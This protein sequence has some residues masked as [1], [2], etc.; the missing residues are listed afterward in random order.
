MRHLLVILSSLTGIIAGSTATDVPAAPILQR[1]TEQN[2]IKPNCVDSKRFITVSTLTGPI[3]GHVALNTSCV[4]E[5]LGIPYAKSPVGHLRFAPPEP[6]HRRR[7]AYV[8]SNFGYDCPLA[9]SRPVDYPGFTPQA[10]RIIRYYTSGAGNPQS[11]DCLTLNIW[12]KSTP[13]AVAKNKPVIVFFYGGRK[14]GV[15]CPEFD[16]G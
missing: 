16:P 9:P 1:G 5:Y 14:S 2:N 11:E 7:I 13:K 3:I 10:P 8:A 6:L 12:S 4:V 15:F